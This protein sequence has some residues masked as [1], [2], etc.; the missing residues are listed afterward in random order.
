MTEVPPSR[1]AEVAPA[2][3]PGTLSQTFSTSVELSEDRSESF[4]RTVRGSPG[5]Q[6]RFMVWILTERYTFTDEDGNSFTDP[7]YEFAPDDLFRRGVATA[8]QAADFPL[9]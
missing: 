6:T 3:T 8:L 7:A 2:R 5:K 1:A 4:S 9:P